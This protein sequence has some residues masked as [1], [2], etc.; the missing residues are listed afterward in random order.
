MFILSDPDFTVEGK[1][2]TSITDMKTLTSSRVVKA[3]LPNSYEKEEALK[4]IG[5]GD[6]HQI[7]CKEILFGLRPTTLT[8]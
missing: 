8:G 6:H 1:F 5:Q 2:G 4:F 3:S 7:L